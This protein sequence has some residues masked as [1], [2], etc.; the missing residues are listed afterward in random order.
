[1][2]WHHSPSYP[3]YCSSNFLQP[4]YCSLQLHDFLI[5]S[6]PLGLQLPHSFFLL[7]SL[8]LDCAHF[9]ALLIHRIL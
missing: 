1:M 6:L 9:C 8:V 2:F 5:G 7:H 4:L 3:R